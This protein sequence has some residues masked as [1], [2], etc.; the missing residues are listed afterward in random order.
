M[1]MRKAIALDVRLWIEGED[2]PAHDFS[3]S[4]IEAVRRIIDAARET[5]PDLSVT[6]RSI[7]ERS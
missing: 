2:D 5:H 7:R 4:M 1:T 6:I 3:Q